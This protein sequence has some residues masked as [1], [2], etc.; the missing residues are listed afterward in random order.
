MIGVEINIPCQYLQLMNYSAQAIPQYRTYHRTSSCVQIKIP[1]STRWSGFK[2]DGLAFSTRRPSRPRLSTSEEPV[3]D[4]MT[5]WLH[6]LVSDHANVA[7]VVDLG[8]RHHYSRGIGG[9][10]HCA[11]PL[12][13][14]MRGAIT[15]IIV[16]LILV[17]PWTNAVFGPPRSHA[18]IHPRW[19]SHAKRLND[20]NATKGLKR[21]TDVNDTNTSDVI[22]VGAGIAGKA[23]LPTP[24]WMDDLR[25]VYLCASKN[26]CWLSKA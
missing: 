18:K 9:V 11:Y 10:R 17:F 19:I 13:R 8:W 24:M 25:W 4:R 16:T 21:N 20:T 1:S 6:W 12:G 7:W 5:G 15:Y 3:S 26:T 14:H 22:V 2:H 23:C